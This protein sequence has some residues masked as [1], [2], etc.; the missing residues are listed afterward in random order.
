MSYYQSIAKTLKSKASVFV[1]TTAF[2]GLCSATTFDRAN[3]AGEWKLN[4]SKS[5]LG[6]SAAWNNV[7]IR[8]Q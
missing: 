5:E 3:F 7:E 4:E 6:Q 8:L 1:L 2:I